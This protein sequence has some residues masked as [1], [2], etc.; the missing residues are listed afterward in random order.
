MTSGDLTKLCTTENVCECKQMSFQLLFERTGI[1]KILE[2]QRIKI[3]S[4]LWV[5]RRRSFSRRTYASIMEVRI[6]E[7]SVF[8]DLRLPRP[9][10]SAV[11]VTM[12][13]VVQV[14]RSTCRCAPDAQVRTV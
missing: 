14:A 10:K 3:V 1:G 5:R 6:E 12:T 9:D 7:C 11:A 8:A 13:F 4:K 2:T